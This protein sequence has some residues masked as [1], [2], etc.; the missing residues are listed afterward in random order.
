[1]ATYHPSRKLSKLDK[2]DMR[3]TEGEVRTNAEVMY[4]CESLHMGEQR[5][6]DQLKPT[7]RS[8]VPT[9]DVGLKTCRKQWTIG[10]SGEKGP[11]IS[12]L[13][14]GH[15]EDEIYIYI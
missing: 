9:Q 3:D 14:V 2:P 11:G 6:D 1:M 10:K 13:M 5:Q 12:V 8:S 4:S 7:Y 15:D